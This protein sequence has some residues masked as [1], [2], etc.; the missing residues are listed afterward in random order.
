M[1]PEKEHAIYLSMVEIAHIENSPTAQVKIKV[2]TNDMEDALA[3]LFEERLQL[4]DKSTCRN[5]SRYVEGYFAKY[6]KVSVNEK[7]K[8]LSLTGCEF[9]SDA[10]WFEFSLSSPGQWTSVAVNAPFLMELFPTQSN[11]VSIAYHG[12]RQFANLTKARPEQIFKF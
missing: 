3:N 9:L 1:L 8:S 6:L 2:F 11:V 10:I 12:K 5:A 4:T 7:V